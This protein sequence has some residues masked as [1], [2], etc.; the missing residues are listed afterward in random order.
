MNFYTVLLHVPMISISF[1]K[2]H[3][4][5][6]PYGRHVVHILINL[7]NLTQSQMQ[8]ISADVAWSACVSVLGTTVSSAK[9]TESIKMPFGG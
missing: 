8:A 1:N 5:I 6:L 9:T 3:G 2:L 7:H 4:H